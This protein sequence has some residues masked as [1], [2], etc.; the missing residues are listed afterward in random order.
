M[1]L[2]AIKLFISLMVLLLY[3]FIVA[4]QTFA[5]LITFSFLYYLFN[6][7]NDCFYAKISRYLFFI[8]LFSFLLLKVLLQ[9]KQNRFGFERIYI[10]TFGRQLWV[11]YN[12]YRDKRISIPLPVILHSK[13][14]GWHL[15]L[16]SQFRKIMEHTKASQLHPKAA[17]MK[18]KLLNTM[19]RELKFVPWIYHLPKQLVLSL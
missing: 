19:P 8:V 6:C 4:E 16:S 9:R 1:Q 3:C 15:F 18:A 7:G 14:T 11:A 12:Q 10:W 2:K 17:I 13:Q 5:F